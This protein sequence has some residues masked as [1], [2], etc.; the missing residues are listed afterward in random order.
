M[1]TI[2]PS[3][4]SLASATL[5]TLLLAPL[6][7]AQRDLTTFPACMTDSDCLAVSEETAADY[8]CFQYM[9][10]PWN[11]TE[12]QGSLTPCTKPSQCGAVGQG[13][14]CFRHSNRR[15]V[16]SGFCVTKQ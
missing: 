8:K 7:L 15:S 14:S 13:A 4:T 12:L 6:V 3:A 16:F 10:F 2:P 1:S 9:C 11:S 5:A